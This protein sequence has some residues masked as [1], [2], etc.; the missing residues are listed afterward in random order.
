M[1]QAFAI[2]DVGSLVGDP[3]RAAMLVELMDGRARSAGELAKCARI[4]PA[5]AS[6]H[7]G[8]LLHGQLLSVEKQGRHRY[9]RL[10]SERVGD[11]LEALG[12]IATGAAPRSKALSTRQA[13]L[14]HARTC[15][16][17]L[18]G[19]VAVRLR[20][21]LERE[22]VVATA[23]ERDYR[24][25]RT[26]VVWLREHFDVDV[27]E[28]TRMRRA[29]ARKCLDWTERRPHIAGALGASLLVHMR[30]QKWLVPT[31]Q[32][33]ALR[34]TDRGLIELRRLGIQSLGLKAT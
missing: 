3:S 7:L 11:A 17:H 5:A 26:G 18:A 33:R 15:Y 13:T 23:G 2:A 24:V 34:I 12:L 27:D 6:M 4:T 32:S 30:S 31:S 29:T 21:A 1:T 9:Y 8:K 16:D 22:R 14:R 25:T 19:T 20:E 10:A 28:L